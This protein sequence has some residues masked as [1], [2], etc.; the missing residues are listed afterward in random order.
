M[1]NKKLCKYCSK[2]LMNK[3]D[4]KLGWHKGSYKEQLLHN[5]QTIPKDFDS[6]RR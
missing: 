4:I 1:K 2:P 5:K 6:V 3:E